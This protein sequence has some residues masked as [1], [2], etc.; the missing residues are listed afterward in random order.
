MFVDEAVIEL[1]AGKGGDGMVAFHREKFVDMGGPSGGDGGHGGDIVL[2]ATTNVNTLVELRNAR[3]V[4]A[5]H[6]KP[7]LSKN[8]SG[9]SGEDQVVPVPVGTLVYDAATGELMADLTER[10]QR[11]IVAAG[12]RGGLGNQHFA[13]PSNRAPRKATPGE[14]GAHLKVRLE[15]KLLADV[16]LVGYP[17]VGKSTLISVISNA[18]PKIADYPFT[19]L[20]PNL[21]VVPWHDYREFVVADIPG[22]IEGAHDGVG[23]GHQFLRH[24]ERTNLL[25]HLIEV[26]PRADGQ[27]EEESDRDPIKDYEILCGELAYFNPQLLKRPQMIVLTKADLP[28]VAAREPE[29]RAHFEQGLGLPFVA[30]SAATRQGISELIDMLGRAIFEGTLKDQQQPAWYAELVEEAELWREQKALE[31]ELGEDAEDAPEVIWVFEDEEG[32][33]LDGDDS[34]GDDELGEEDSDADDSDAEGEEE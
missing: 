8:K 11:Y 5:Q 34:E 6:G 13:T 30:I 24:V 7:G 32:R 31:E 4:R 22:L 10:D 16:G 1:F 14:A 20:V 15:L 23:L 18:R 2:W 21:G 12:G 9:K 19:T 17:S 29:L 26:V 33:S 25:L 28:F 3:H 27:A